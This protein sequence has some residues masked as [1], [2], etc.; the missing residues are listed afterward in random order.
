MI[1]SVAV[2]TG[3]AGRGYLDEAI[4]SVDEQTYPLIKHYLLTDAIISHDE[5]LVLRGKHQSENRFVSYW[6]TKVGGLD[7]EC[8]R[9]WS[10]AASLINEDIVMFLNDDDWYK[11]THVQDMVN[12]ISKGF[13]WAYSFRDIHNPDGSFAFP[14]LCESLGEAHVV[15]NR[16]W[17][18]F[19]EQ[20][21][22]AM[23]AHC[24][25]AIAPYFCIK[26]W[27]N[28]R[29][30]YMQLKRLYPRFAGSGKHSVCF[31]LGGNELS[32]TKLFFEKGNAF[33][34]EAYGDEMPWQKFMREQDEKNAAA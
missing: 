22:V 11:P 25:R 26:G 6:P 32:V 17:E 5:Y 12:I 7:W 27:A 20:G 4:K 30:T 3:T 1:P 24:Y 10:S 31:R 29:T 16:Q 19:A 9:L 13:D 2:I 14:D 23:A 33:M 34:K 15:W 18:N 8:R 21:S 28:D